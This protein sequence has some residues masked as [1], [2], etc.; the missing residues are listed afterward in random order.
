[1]IHIY[2]GDGKGKTT[3]AIG[4]ALRMAGNG[5]RVRV[6]QFLKGSESG[7]IAYLRN[8]KIEIER[9]KNDCG[10]YWNMSDDE[11][12]EVRERH[13]ELLRRALSDLDGLD[14]LVLDEL[15]AA[16]NCGLV[17]MELVKAAVEGCKNTELVMT[18]R[19]PDAY[20]MEK[21]DYISEIKKIK[22]PFDKG[23]AARKGIEY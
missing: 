6:L 18:G 7:E 17:D 22:H 9:L 14:M 21:A 15:F 3:A 13:N 11:K 2:C 23:V 12:S 1:M 4:L 19:E 5:K 10:F 8:S 16:V 20:F